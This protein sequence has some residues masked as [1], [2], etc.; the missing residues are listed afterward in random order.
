[1]MVELDSSTKT[2]KKYT[3]CGC[4]LLM[5][6]IG[7]TL[8]VIGWMVW[9]AK[10]ARMVEDE[11]AKIRDAG[12]PIEASDLASFYEIPN[13]QDDTTRWWVTAVTT[14]ES[15]AFNEAALEFPIVGDGPDIPPVG[16]PWEQ[17]E[18]VEVFLAEYK[19][20]MDSVHQATS[21]GG[22]AR[23]DRDFEEGISM[24]LPNIQ[25]IRGAA[26]TL[27]LEARVA[28]HRGDSH[29]VA[30]ALHS[31]FVTSN[32]AAEDPILISQLVRIAI[33]GMAANELQSAI[34]SVEFSGDDLAML[35]KDV[36]SMD[37]QRGLDRSLMGERVIGIT[38]FRNP[39]RFSDMGGMT[40]PCEQ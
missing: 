9:S 35:R 26:R 14:F 21:L 18:A 10:A 11:L 33:A 38:T 32:A 31:L 8:P 16:E 40:G 4:V 22:Y 37:L 23:F 5:F 19:D 39:G 1:M 12:E 25:G 3:P 17:L 34:E 28:A 24:L 30:Q 2:W 29:A 13:G 20:E 27:S 36:Q 15:Q 7:I 6:V